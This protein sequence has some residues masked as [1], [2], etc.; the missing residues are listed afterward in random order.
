MCDDEPGVPGPVAGAPSDDLERG[1]VTHGI[2]RANIRDRIA[3]TGHE[4]VRDALPVPPGQAHD[5]GAEQREAAAVAQLDGHGV[6]VGGQD[7]HGRDTAVDDDEPVVGVNGKGV[8]TALGGGHLQDV[9]AV[10][11][12]VDPGFLIHLGRFAR[13]GRFQLGHADGIPVI[14]ATRVADN[15][16]INIG[17]H[18]V[19]GWV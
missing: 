17:R 10:V 2:V 13:L 18:A 7:G 4:L 6:Q 1:Q 5:D 8:R 12:K 19:G 16:R 15:E 14:R 11:R 3:V 9:V